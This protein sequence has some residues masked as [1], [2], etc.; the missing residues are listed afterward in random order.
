VVIG[1]VPTPANTS[2]SAQANS[3]YGSLFATVTAHMNPV[4]QFNVHAD[5]TF[6]DTLTLMG[7]VGNGEISFG[8]DGTVTNITDIASTVTFQKDAGTPQVLSFGNTNILD[9][10][11]QF[12]TAFYSFSYGVPFT[13][14]TSA[15]ARTVGNGDGFGTS[16]LD[17]EL[18]KIFVLDQNGSPF[19]GYSITSQSGTAYPLPE[20]SSFDLL[21]TLAA[22]V[23]GLR[24][25]LR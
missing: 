21:G 13:I 19:F 6:L 3:A 14:Q 10:P 23:G 5:A 24:L 12:Q 16:T 17:A 1:G 2:L 15:D 11:F 22:L 4:G 18:D 9:K 8:F 25:K 7:G 20:P